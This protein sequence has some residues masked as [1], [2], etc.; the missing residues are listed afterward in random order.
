MR[1]SLATLIST[2]CA[3]LLC[4]MGCEGETPT[5]AVVQN[6]FQVV[7][8]AGNPPSGV[9][10][11]RTWYFT[12][13]FVD[14]VAPGSSSDTQRTVPATD[15]VYAVLAPGLDPTS[16]TPPVTLI[17][18]RSKS[19]V[20]VA[21]G[22]SLAIDVSDLTF[23]GNCAAGTPLSQ[24]DADFITQRIFPGDFASVTYDA[25]TCAAR[26]IQGDGGADEGGT[27]ADG[28]VGT[29]ASLDA[30]GDSGG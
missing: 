15:Y 14:P 10:I 22:E 11:Y 9:T 7:P 23:D 16:A 25:K 6:S 1:T 28:G 20:V 8:D 18:V 27:D 5:S 3:A 2:T 12:T 24:D 17:P 21:R 4:W 29:D 30:P 13:A 26:P 19:K